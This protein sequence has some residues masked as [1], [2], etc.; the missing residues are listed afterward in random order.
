MLFADEITSGLVGAIIIAIPA[1]GAWIVTLLKT[2]NDLRKQAR[3]DAIAEWERIVARQDSEMSRMQD[4]VDKLYEAE[5]DCLKKYGESAERLAK[6]EGVVIQLTTDIR[7]LQLIGKDAHP[8]ITTPAI[9][10]TSL[11]GTIREAS[12][13]VGPLLHWL[14]QQ[15]RGKNVDALI[16][17]RLKESYRQGLAK[18]KDDI[19]QVDPAKPLQTTAIRQDGVEVD[20]SIAL[21]SWESGGAEFLTAEIRELPAG[22]IAVAAASA[23]SSDHG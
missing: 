6:Q 16:P 22:A 10:I 5:R 15:L 17:E 11:D 9:I 19:R 2:K 7:R 1:I 4:K 18:I 21:S 3:S 8:G 13:Q 23:K 12:A 20:V 14:P